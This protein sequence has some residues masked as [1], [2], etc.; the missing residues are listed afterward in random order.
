MF[1]LF[2]IIANHTSMESCFIQRSDETGSVLQ[3]L[4]SDSECVFCTAS[5]GA[6][7]GD[8]QGKGSGRFP[9][10]PQRLRLQTG[11]QH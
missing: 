6:G 4:V 7:G 5:A 11:Q 9:E 1:R 2:C 10:R 3:G 8:H